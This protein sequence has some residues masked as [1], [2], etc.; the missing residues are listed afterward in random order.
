[1]VAAAIREQETWSDR[2]QSEQP[3]LVVAASKPPPRLFDGLEDLEEEDDDTEEQAAAE[4]AKRREEEQATLAASEL[5][6]AMTEKELGEGLLE[7]EGLWK[8]YRDEDEEPDLDDAAEALLQES[9]RQDV[10]RAPA[11]ET[12]AWTVRVLEELGM[13]DDETF[14]VVEEVLVER[15]DELEPQSVVDAVNSYGN[16]YWVSE[17]LTD[18][19]AVAARR[20][21]KDFT[22]REV[23][24][25]A[26]GLI[27][28]GGI[29]DTRHAGLFFEMRQRVNLPAVDKFMRKALNRDGHVYRREH[30]DTQLYLEAFDKMPNSALK[31]KA[32]KH[33]S[34]EIDSS[35]QKLLERASLL[36]AAK[37]PAPG[38]GTPSEGERSG[39]PA[40]T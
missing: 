20:Q 37:L 29:D 8:Q 28:M 30:E 18:A 27:R 6:A 1:V 10:P 14:K 19:L 25:L 34:A 12:A 7:L 2:Q 15:A 17:N 3:S 16:V 32:L 23:V 4:E 5:E 40:S 22:S 35:Q 31:A 26:N 11:V 13:D 24:I 39:G 38:V 36:D 33:F 21:L 9:L